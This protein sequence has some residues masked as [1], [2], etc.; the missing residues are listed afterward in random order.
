MTIALIASA[1]FSFQYG[2]MPVK[3]A[4]SIAVDN[5][6]KVTVEWTAYPAYDAE[7]WVL[8]M[9]NPSAE[10]SA[11]LSE[12]NDIDHLVRL[13]PFQTPLRNVAVPGDRAVITMKGCVDGRDY[14]D[15]DLS[16]ASEFSAV[17]HYF[18]WWSRYNFTVSS[19]GGRSSE[20]ECPFFEITQEGQGEI[21]ALGWT[22][23]WKA[24]FT[25]ETDGIRI[26]AGLK[27][28]RFCLMPGEKLR[29][30]RVLVMRYGKGEDPSNKFRRLVRRHLSHVASHPG[31]RE[32]IDACI[33]WG[34]L[35]SEE[36]AR[37]IRRIEERGISFEDYWVDAGW[38]GECKRCED[39]Y[40]GDWGS[41]TGDWTM[42]PAIHA[43]G[44][45]KVKA[46]ANRAG[47]KMMLWFE[48]ER[49]MKTTKFFKKHGD[50][51]LGNGG[52]SYLLNLGNA[53]A[54]R[55]L[56]G[57]ADGYVRDLGLSCYRQDF[58]FQPA[59][60]FEAADEENR[61]GIAEIRHVLGMYEVWDELLR[62]NQGLVIDNCASG[63]RRIDLETLRRSLT[64]TRSDY[65]GGFNANADV[66]QVQHIGFSRLFPCGGCSL[67]MSD[68]YSLRSAYSTSTGVAYWQTVHHKE[69]DVDWASAKKS[70]D[71]YLRIRRFFP[72]DFYNLGSAVL[73]PTAWAAW[74]YFDPE[75]KEGV[76]LAFRRAESP[77]E[78]AKF[79]LKGLP[80]GAKIETENLDTGE[81]GV[82][83]G[84]LEIRLPE[85]RSS[86]IVLYRVAE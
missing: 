71:E 81:K 48:P 52:D 14:N 27:N 12:I 29:T 60:I 70:H 77:S 65:Q 36:L 57:L 2:D 61:R 59:P 47:G 34:A 5:R 74:Q 73:D 23:D 53:D 58:N 56:V 64:M 26:R 1:C 17:P 24:T 63:G 25:N 85:R 76:V 28:A 55:Y 8:W 3:G 33:F 66:I 22:G 80:S 45:H 35:S 82:A 69:S 49:V 44:M 9:E 84:E 32:S 30:S 16:S 78:L 62:R 15:S 40:V 7:E 46:A 43:D 50:W 68:L 38:Y 10:K 18:K 83:D 72:C 75:A 6:L 19:T 21:I 79:A 13:P 67:K 54:R 86:A 41:Y 37:R 4:D 42:N 39:A 11:V 31:T 20:A 51:L